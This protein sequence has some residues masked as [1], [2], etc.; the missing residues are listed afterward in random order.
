MAPSRATKAKQIANKGQRGQSAAQDFAIALVKNAAVVEQF[1]AQQV[2]RAVAPADHGRNDGYAVRR[3]GANHVWFFPAGKHG[4]GEKVP[5]KILK[6]GGSLGNA[7]RFPD[8]AKT[9]HLLCG[10]GNR[11]SHA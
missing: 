5:V 4:E 6:D 8:G 7:K 1:L 3:L 9:R 11:D 2:E 10:S